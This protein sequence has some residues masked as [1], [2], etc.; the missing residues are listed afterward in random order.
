MTKTTKKILMKKPAKLNKT[1]R[2]T[3]KQAEDKIVK[4]FGKNDK[5]LTSGQIAEKVDLNRTYVWKIL[6]RLMKNKLVKRQDGRYYK[7]S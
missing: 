1:E 4:A 6:R 7:L 3:G 5:L 2:L